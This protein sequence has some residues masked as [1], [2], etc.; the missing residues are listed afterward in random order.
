LKKYFVFFD[1]KTIL[2]FLRGYGKGS[3]SKDYELLVAIALSKS[4]EDMWKTPNV[5]G[6]EI[7]DKYV[8]D[9]PDSDMIS[10]EQV[11]KVLRRYVEEKSPVDIAIAKGTMTDHES[12]G[13]AF[14]LKRFGMNTREKNTSSLI[15]FLNEMP[16]RYP[17]AEV[18]L[19]MILEKG[20]EIHPFEVQKALITDNYPFNKI[21]FMIMM[22]EKIM[23]GEF[24]PKS[25]M[26]EYEPSKLMTEFNF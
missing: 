22:N 9:L 25:G 15:K 24:W 17:K 3:N 11:K 19:F 13:A 16:K 14:Q 21:M 2:Y 26:N 12:K 7:A 8:R 6:F 5:I 23:I 4:L 20:V 18:S 1:R 10:I